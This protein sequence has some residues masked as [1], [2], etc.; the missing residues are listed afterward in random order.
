MSHYD[1]HGSYEQL[2]ASSFCAGK[3]ENVFVIIAKFMS[4]NANLHC[5]LL[6]YRPYLNTNLYIVR[7]YFISEQFS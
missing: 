6:T 4:F 2:S 5:I 3:E 7:M 1:I